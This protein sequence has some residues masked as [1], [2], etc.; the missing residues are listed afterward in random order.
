MFMP[1]PFS[2]S[3]QKHIQEP[4]DFQ[5]KDTRKGKN[6][7]SEIDKTGSNSTRMLLSLNP[8]SPPPSTPEPVYWFDNFPPGF[9]F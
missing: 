6:H 1:I 9:S 5:E 4:M 8:R 3:F 7:V 2:I